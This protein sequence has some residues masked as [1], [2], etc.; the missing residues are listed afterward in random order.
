MLRAFLAGVLLSLWQA[1]APAAAGPDFGVAYLLATASYCAYAVDAADSDFGQARATAC[2]RAAA[3]ADPRHLG[4]LGVAS[5]DV[6]THVDPQH[7]EDGYLLLRTRR[8]LVLAFRGTTPP[9]I[10]PDDDADAPAPGRRRGLDRWGVFLADFFNNFDAGADERGRHAGFG[11]SWRRL[12]AHLQPGCARGRGVDAGCG[13]FGA[14]LRSLRGKNRRLFVT[15][16]S[17][18]GALAVLAALDMPEIAGVDPVVYVFAAPK[19][20]TEDVARAKA[21]IA[22]TWWRFERENDLVPS[23]PPDRSVALWPIFAGSAYAHLGNL[24]FFQKNAAPLVVAA[25]A[26]AAA[27]PRD[28][29]RIPALVAHQFGAVVESWFTID[30]PARVLNSNETLCRAWLDNHFQVLG[31]V[32]ALVRAPGAR[33]F[34]ATGL[35]DEKGRRI[36]WGY[37]EWC[38][39]LRITD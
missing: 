24:T 30:F 10:L 3:A 13:K 18:G 39:Q 16:H 21:A 35:H 26:E 7:A 17:K 11:D 27:V 29:A 20:V 32:G 15:G 37:R 22:A 31:D 14:F 28:L 12:R 34:I 5:R 9:P 8:G 33:D 36:L 4:D 19:A 25:G 6:E 1:T 23:L 2:V 38:G